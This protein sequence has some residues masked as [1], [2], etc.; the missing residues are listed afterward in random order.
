MSSRARRAVAAITA[1]VML[2][3]CVTTREGRIGA[4]DGSDPCRAQ[5]V[6]LDS[7]GNFFAENIIQ[8]AVAGAVGGAIL[9]GLIAA[10]TG[11][12]G[13]DVAAGAAIGA[14][15]GGVTGAAAGYW[16]ARQRQASDQASLNLSIASD[17]AKEN[18]ELDRTQFAF[19]QLMDCRFATAN[20][21]RS[22][23]RAGRTARPTGE[24]QMANLRAMTQRDLQ[25]AQSINQR[26]GARGAEFDTAIENVAPGAKQQVAGA[27][28]SRSVPVQARATVP[29]KLRPDPAAPEI[30]QVR[31]NERVTVSPASGG[32]A[33]VETP[34]GVRG[35]APSGS[36]P[37]AR[38]LGSRPA[39][40]GGTDGDV[41]SL[42]ASNIA[43]RD[44]FTESVANAE[45]LA[46]GQGFELAS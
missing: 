37:E 40:G 34:S 27:R 8:G 4:D 22:D 21:I 29:L 15:A 13:G 26:I 43:R 1:A 28:V 9:G 31:A 39:I 16:Q 36:F 6:A 11:G 44:N 32:F 30:A 25:L 35:Y 24:A 18:A 38:S 23:V 20:R 3:G 45:R 41:R 5:L 7:T 33:L 2:A 12:R 17:L 14:A 10:A 42:A 19:N 46:Q